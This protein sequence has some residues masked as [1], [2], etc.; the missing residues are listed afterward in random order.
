MDT[1]AYIA[2]RTAAEARVTEAKAKRLATSPGRLPKD[3]GRAV[4]AAFPALWR[5]HM[6]EVPGGWVDVILAF[7]E[8]AT[9]LAPSLVV[10]DAKEKYGGLRLNL[11]SDDMRW[12]DLDMGEVYESISLHT[13]QDCGE[14]GQPRTDRGWDATLCDLHDARRDPIDG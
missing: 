10:E 3:W 6:C 2:L 8:H 1:D 14:P 9:S 7:S 12:E 13:C 5:P 4:E 11:S